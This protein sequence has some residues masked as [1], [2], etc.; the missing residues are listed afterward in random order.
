VH[1]GAPSDLFGFNNPALF[2]LLTRADSETNLAKRA[3]L[4]QQASILVMKYLPMVPYVHSSP[5]LAFQ[6]KVQGYT[7]SPVSLEPF[8]T[9]FFGT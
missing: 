1:F 8:S 9:V 6:K 2:N 7:P 4:Y 5:A 3:Q